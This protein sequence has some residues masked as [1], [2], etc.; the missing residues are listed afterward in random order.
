MLTDMLY[1]VRITKNTS[2]ISDLKTKKLDKFDFG[3]EVLKLTQEYKDYVNKSHITSSSNLK[4][5]FRYLMEDVDESSSMHDITVTG[6]NLQ[7]RKDASNLH[8]RRL[9]FNMA[10]LP[11]GGYTICIELFPV[12]MNNVSLDVVNTSNPPNYS[13]TTREALFT[14]TNG[15]F[16]PL[17]TFF[18]FKRPRNT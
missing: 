10:K 14:C 1:N 3:V 15:G 2:A 4:D 13:L 16:H 11:E 18:G 6:I 8:S 12:T 5:E 17:N 7:I 9:G